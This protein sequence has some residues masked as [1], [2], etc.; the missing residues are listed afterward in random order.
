MVYAICEHDLNTWN[1]IPNFNFIFELLRLIFAQSIQMIII[2]MKCTFW[3]KNFFLNIYDFTRYCSHEWRYEKTRAEDIRNKTCYYIE[4]SSKRYVFYHCMINLY[5][6]FDINMGSKFFR[7]WKNIF[8]LYT[9][10]LLIETSMLEYNNSINID[11]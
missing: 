5:Q 9:F 6:G 7:Q 3:Y 10:S 11:S 2:I 4:L 1:L 8:Y